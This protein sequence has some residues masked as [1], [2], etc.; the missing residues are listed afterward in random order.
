MNKWKTLDSKVVLDSP[1]IKVIEDKIVDFEGKKHD[2]YHLDPGFGSVLVV[3]VKVNKDRTDTSYIM[4][5][6]YR[7]P[8]GMF[9]L[10]FPA[11]GREAGESSKEAAIRELKEETGYTANKLKFIY[12]LFV[13]GGLTGKQTAVFMAL[14]DGEPNDQDLDTG[15]KGAGLKVREVSARDLH[16]L[17]L[18]NELVSGQSMAAL[19]AV[20]LQGKNAIKYLNNI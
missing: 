3:P 12:S 14:I 7:H 15:E 16:K 4:V 20:M 19:L 6:Q 8:I 18:D 17:V 9:Q 1:Y 13:D 10:E 5:E 2:Y 11:G